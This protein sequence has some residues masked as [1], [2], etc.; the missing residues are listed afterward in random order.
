MKLTKAD[1]NA[2]RSADSSVC[3]DFLKGTSNEY[4]TGVG[5]IRC[6]AK[7]KMPKG[8]ESGSVPDAEYFIQCEGKIRVFKIDRNAIDWSQVSAY[9][10]FFVYKYDRDVL[11]T[12]FDFLKPDDDLYLEFM[13]NSSNCLKEANLHLDQLTAIVVRGSKEYKFLLKVKVSSNSC[14][15]MIQGV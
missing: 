2:M 6:Y 4:G 14:A 11:S 5:R 9:E 1:I 12:F 15:R 3:F 8:F 13:A 7:A 10:H